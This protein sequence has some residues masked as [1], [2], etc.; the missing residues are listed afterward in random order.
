MD[1]PNQIEVPPS[2][3]A[4]YATPSGRRLTAPMATVRTRYELC[5]DMAQMLAEQAATALFKTGSSER[6]VLHRFRL[7]LSGEGGALQPPEADW[8]VTRLAEILGWELPAEE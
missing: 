4:L 3:Q 7:A 8:V 6:E 1:D 2:F 5:E